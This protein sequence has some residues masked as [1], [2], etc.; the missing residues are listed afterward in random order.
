MLVTELMTQFAHTVESSMAMSEAAE[1]MRDHNV[2][3]LPVLEGERLTGMLTDRD[4]VVRGLAE[5]KDPELTTIREIMTPRVATVFDDQDLDDAIQVMRD[6]RVRRVAVISHDRRLLG[7]LS[8][9][10]LPHGHPGR[11]ELEEQAQDVPTTVNTPD[12]E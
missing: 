9:A 2:G 10:D 1:L 12:G 11:A 6:N 4:L 7:V 3:L 8:E 5:G